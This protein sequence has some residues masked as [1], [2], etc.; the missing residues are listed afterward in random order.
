MSTELIQ[1]TVCDI[2]GD[3]DVANQRHYEITLREFSTINGA[4]LWPHQ[5]HI[6]KVHKVA[7]I[8]LNKLFEDDTRLTLTT[9]QM[10][11]VYNS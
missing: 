1:H 5:I 10:K 11:D 8:P 2:C 7:Q 3:G 4:H 9:K 6:C